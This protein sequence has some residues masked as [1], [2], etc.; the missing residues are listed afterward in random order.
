M[1]VVQQHADVKKTGSGAARKN[2]VKAEGKLVHEDGVPACV[3]MAIDRRGTPAVY[4]RR[5]TKWGAS[6]R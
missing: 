5:A 6:G 2:E 4:E 3:P 1:L